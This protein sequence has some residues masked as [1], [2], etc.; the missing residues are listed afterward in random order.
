MEVRVPDLPIVGDSTAMAKVDES[1]D[2]IKLTVSGGQDR[3]LSDIRHGFRMQHS[4]SI[5]HIPD[6]PK[7]DELTAM[8]KI[9]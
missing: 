1:T 5:L 2:A 3:N 7:V 6:L 4:I 8:P 9:D